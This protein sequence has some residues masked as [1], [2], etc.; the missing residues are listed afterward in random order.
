MEKQLEHNLA[1]L[2]LK[3]QTILHIPERSVQEVIKQLCDIHYLSEPLLHHKVKMIL[4]EYDSEIDESIVKQ[5]SSAVSETNVMTTFCGKVG[6]LATTKKR[7]SYVSKNF[8]LVMPV[9]YVVDKDKKS[10]VYVPIQQ[11]LQKLLSRTDVLDKA[12]SE[13]IHVPNE[14]KTHVDGVYFRENGLLTSD[15]FTI[16][17]GLY[18][19]DFEV[20]NPLGTSKKK[21]KMCA[22]YWVIVNMP[23]KYRA[24]LNSIQ[25]AL[26]CNTTT[27]KECGYDKV[28]DPLIH[29][30]MSLEKDGVYIEALG[31][32]VKGT[33]LYVAADNLGAHAL[34]GFYENF[35]VD[36][37]CRFCMASRSDTQEQEVRSGAFELRDKD[38]HDRQVQ[39]VMEDP[40]LGRKYGV[41]KE[42]PLTAKLEPDLMHDLLEGIVPVELSLCLSDLISK[43]YFNLET[44][45]Q[46]IRSFTYTFTDKTDQPQ[47]ITKGFSTKGT[48]G[49]NAH[50][51]WCLIRLLPFL[52]GQYVPPGEKA[53]EVLMLV[54]DIVEL[55]VA[56]RF[57]DETLYFLECKLA[58]HSELL[59]STFPELRL[60]P[61]HQYIEHYPQLIKA[62]GPLCDV[63]T[64]R[65]EGKHKFFK[66]VIRDAQNYRNVA[67]TLAVK[68][69]KAVSYHLD[70]SSFF[71][72]SVEME[73]VTTVSVSSFP[74]NIQMVLRQKI[75]KPA[76][77]F[78]ASSICLDGVT[79]KADMVVSAGSCSGLPDFRQI[80]QIVA[81]HTEIMFVC[82]VMSAWYHE[83]LRSYEVCYSDVTPPPPPLC[84][85][86]LSELN[87][88][89]PLSAYRIGGKLM[90][91]LKRYILC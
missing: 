28:L 66:K 80:T 58:E 38:R 50:E 55:V 49:G 81:V 4:K 27:V 45:N 52:V 31:A 73:K 18:I 40:E 34:A 24:S 69:Q 21:H 64:M 57:T 43:G 91:T 46:A 16:A 1:A 35:S 85:V 86:P 75:H 60:R 41:K 83:H 62:F 22:V 9:E 42:C 10:V 76:A 29:D 70:S 74:D 72:P 2:F 82:R 8:P 44:L 71:K 87:D 14:Y 90:V 39:E 79:Y 51:N 68:H 59:Q 32:S 6:S 30:L 77:V 25:L 63:W 48:I 61:K 11:M 3:M 15:E 65:F 78:V 54:K 56:P 36:K 23:A 5:V 89:F 47:P 20:A 19:D 67:L 12:M 7:A 33:V 88:V 84:V 13:E 26:I 37:F 17:I 53:W